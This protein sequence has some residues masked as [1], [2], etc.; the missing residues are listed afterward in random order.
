MMQESLM[1]TIENLNR[2]VEQYKKDIAEG[3]LV[4]VC[5]NDVDFNDGDDMRCLMMAQGAVV[6]AMDKEA[7]EAL[8]GVET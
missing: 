6:M 1:Q 3:R 7:E 2:E 5:E 4:R 8:K